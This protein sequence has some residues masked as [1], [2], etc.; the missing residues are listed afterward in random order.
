MQIEYDPEK[1]ARNPLIHDG[2][3]FPEAA[4][5]LLDPHALTHED[6]DADGEERFVTLGLSKQARLLIVVWTERGD[7]IRL[8]SAWKANQPQR[9]RY[10]Q[11]F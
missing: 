8:I 4:T 6:T 10:E 7:R 11:Q 9:K 2:V 3:T 5:A 1:A